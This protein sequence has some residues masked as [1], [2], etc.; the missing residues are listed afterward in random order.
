M[1]NEVS[2]L[3]KHIY[4]GEI[5]EKIILATL[6]ASLGFFSKY[7]LDQMRSTVGPTGELLNSL[8][9]DNLQQKN[10]MAA[11][12]HSCTG[13]QCLNPISAAGYSSPAVRGKHIAREQNC[14][15]LP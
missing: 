8:T 9:V 11:C 2:V 15:F 6:C 10:N 4:I 13:A 7:I 5:S 1:Y 12:V 3:F 14:C